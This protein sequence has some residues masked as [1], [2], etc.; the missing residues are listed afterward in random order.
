MATMKNKDWG[1][2]TLGKEED[3]FSADRRKAR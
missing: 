3:A 2:A 1:R